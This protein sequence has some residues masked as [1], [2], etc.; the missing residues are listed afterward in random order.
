M[1]A[2]LSGRLFLYGFSDCDP[3]V[4]NPSG[5]PQSWHRPKDPDHYGTAMGNMTV[6]DKAGLS[7]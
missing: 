2:V 4:S 7:Q 6:F 5:T 3:S 1:T